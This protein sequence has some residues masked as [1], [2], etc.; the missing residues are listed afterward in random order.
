MPL[1][2]RLRELAPMPFSSFMEKA[3]FDS[4]AGYYSTHISTIGRRG[5]FSTSS[6]LSTSLSRGIA[7]WLKERWRENPS[8][9]RNVIEVGAGN[10][11]MA[12]GILDNLG[13]LGRRKLKYHIVETSAPLVKK[14]Q[15]ILGKTRKFQ[16]HRDMRKALNQA[17]GKA[18][19]ISNELVDAF[20]AELLQWHAKDKTWHQVLLIHDG[21]HWKA[22]PG[23]PVQL[24]A[25]SSLHGNHDF[26]TGQKV[27]RHDS[28]LDWLSGWIPEWHLGEMLTI[29]YGG[30]F[31]G[32][33]HRRPEGTLRAYFA[34]QR[35]ESLAEILSR[36]G[37]QDLTADI[38]FSDLRARSVPLGLLE[39]AFQT[40]RE[41]ITGQK[42]KPP[43]GDPAT[44]PDG[45]GQAFKVLWQRRP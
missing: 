40:Q 41:F 38:D 29:D 26:L 31:P 7:A 6:T 8:L 45:A 35:L 18:I 44:N 14:Q 16:W 3:L 1:A 19:I 36:P 17:G 39:I 43:P 2:K 12:Q 9:P 21:T 15:V 10:G 23:N 30:M 32:V 24:P 4:D 5:D 13:I 11:L 37:K 33:Y 28:Y 20:P 42:I 34:Q 27:E 25:G 22:I